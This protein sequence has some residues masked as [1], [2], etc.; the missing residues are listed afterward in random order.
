MFERNGYVFQEVSQQNDFGKDAYVDITHDGCFS[1][2]CVAVQIKSGSSYRSSSGDYFIPL[3]QHAHTWRN[4]TVPVFGIVFDPED[5]LLRWLDL[6]GYLRTHP[7]QNNGRVTVHRDSLLTDDSLA[8]GFADAV[9]SYAKPGQSEIAMSLLSDDPATQDEAVIDAWALGRGDAR[10]LTLLRRLIVHLD[11]RATRRAIWTLSHATP[12]PDIFWTA[13]NWIP[14]A[15]KRQVQT[16]FRWSAEEI[17]H[18]FLAIGSD[19]WGRG[20]LGQ[21]LHMLLLLD[22]FVWQSLDSAIFNLLARSELERAVLV[23]WVVLASADDP[24]GTL[25]GIVERHPPLLQSE[26]VREISVALTECNEFDIY[27]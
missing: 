2:L 15:I 27:C 11:V 25:N 20:T 22:A 13:D 9:G 3:D 19:E 18:M 21:S 12:H 23:V 26:W 6:T 8:G 4:S 1:P 7:T 14:D 10:F 24:L 17:E 5:G 16:S